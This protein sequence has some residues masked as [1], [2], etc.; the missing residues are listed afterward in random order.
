MSKIL[1]VTLTIILLTGC[2]ENKPEAQYPNNHPEGAIITADGTV[3]FYHEIWS[4]FMEM[5]Y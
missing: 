3:I 1:L 4:D 5:L 2:V